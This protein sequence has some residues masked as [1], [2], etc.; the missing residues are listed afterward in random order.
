MDGRLARLFES[1]ATS[2]SAI[3]PMNQEHFRTAPFQSNLPVLTG[4]L[5]FWYNEFLGSQITAILSYKEH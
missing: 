3:I 2:T 4:R 5:G 1:S